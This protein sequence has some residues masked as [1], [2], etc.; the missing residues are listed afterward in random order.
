MCERIAALLASEFD[1]VATVAD[2]QAA[3]DA[4][5]SLH[6]DLVV[7]DISMPVLSGLEA[8]A[9]IRNLPNAP[10]IVFLTAYEDPAFVEAALRLGA[11]RVVLKRYMMRQLVPVV[12]QALTVHAV[13]F[14]E[15]AA[16][17]SRVVASFIDDGRGASEAAVVIARSDHRA[18]ILQEMLETTGDAQAGVERGELVMLDADELLSRFMIDGMPCARRF[19]DAV[20][21]IFDRVTTN[22][23]RGVRAYGEMVDVLWASDRQNAA[24]SLEIL[25]NQLAATYRF[26]LLCGYSRERVGDGSG[27]ETIC[28]H[29]SRVVS[30]RSPLPRYAHF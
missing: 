30:T 10:R 9:V 3:V 23:E 2:G 1:V 26:A 19:A 28:S 27:F 25:W 6:P 18:A 8:A 14:Y 4:T 29:H 21:P 22:G 24:V 15:N 11:A 20:A 16:S 17:L 5:T 7:L 12:R 13:H